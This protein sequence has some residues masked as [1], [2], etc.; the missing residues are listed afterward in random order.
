[1]PPSPVSRS[2]RAP[3]LVTGPVDGPPAGAAG[4]AELPAGG[5][6]GLTAGCWVVEGPLDPGTLRG[7]IAR[8][9]REVPL[10]VLGPG[11]VG[12]DGAQWGELIREETAAAEAEPGPARALLA[13][14]DAERSL[15]VVVTEDAL[16]PAAVMRWLLTD[17]A[18]FPAEAGAGSGRLSRSAVGPE[19]DG[20]AGAAER[21]PSGLPDGGD[22]ASGYAR[23]E[24]VPAGRVASRLPFA[25]VPVEASL[26][27]ALAV[28]RVRCGGSPGTGIVVASDAPVAVAPRVAESVSGTVALR[29]GGHALAS[30][31]PVAPGFHAALAVAP[32]A[33]T[34]PERVGACT[35]SAVRPP[36]SVAHHGLLV[37]LEDEQVRI[38]HD[39]GLY[40]EDAVATFAA[41]LLAVLEQ[42]L[43]DRPVYGIVGAG[44]AER[45]ALAEWS[46]GAEGAVPAVC[47][48]T[49]VEEHAV[50]TPDAPAVLCGETEL[51][52]RR[53]DE[54]ANAAR[55]AR[56]ARPGVGPGAR[57]PPATWT[58]GFRR[59]P[60][61]LAFYRG[62][63]LA[64]IS[65]P[66]TYAVA[67][68]WEERRFSVLEEW[69]DIGLT[70]GRH[71]ELISELKP[72]V[73]EYPMRERLCA[74]LMTALYQSQR[75]AEALAVYRN[76]RMAQIKNLGLEP[77]TGLQ[78]LHQKI[79]A[80]EPIAPP[81]SVVAHQPWP[82][83]KVPAQLPPR[84]KDFTGRRDLLQRITSDLRAGGEPRVVALA[85]C[86][87][88]G[89]TALAI[90][91]GL[92]LQ[93][94]FPDGQLYADLRGHTDPVHPQ[95]VLLGFL[96]AF[97]VPEQRIPAGLAARAALFRSITA[98]KRLLIVLDDVAESTRYE[99]LLPSG[100]SAVLCTG[101]ASLLKI[102]GLTEYRVDGLPTD[103]ALDLFASLARRGTVPAALLV[104]PLVPL[105]TNALG[106]GLVAAPV[107]VAALLTALLPGV[108]PV[109]P[110]LLP[111]TA[112]VVAT[113][114]LA[115]AALLPRE[116]ENPVRADLLYLWD[117]DRRAG[118][119]ISGVPADEW[120]DDF[121]PADAEPGSVEDL[122][123]GW[124]VPV[125][126]GPAEA[127][128]L[129]GPRVTTQVVA[130]TAD[131]GRRVRVTAASRRGADQL[132]LLVSGTAV[133]GWSLSGVPGRHADDPAGDAPWELWIRHVPARGAELELELGA[134]PATIRVVDRTQGLPGPAA[135][136]PDGTRPPALGVAS[137]GEASLAATTRT[138]E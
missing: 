91:A 131:G 121:L 125:R 134:G 109:L 28:L 57:R 124:R 2:V 97:G 122:W 24:R 3:V 4:P 86:G 82:G 83:A 11:S 74:Q 51:T 71:A 128:P 37:A 73:A 72:L 107:A 129:P 7:R 43:D 61:A 19:D 10:T 85:G 47:L 30:G 9:G 96:D 93:Q 53:L 77:S 104:F 110:R 80:G 23:T 117:A 27:V 106:L 135:D 46:R 5:R 88:A 70:L 115:G 130:R 114:M 16:P 20:R 90:H 78:E 113:A 49:L 100:E 64:D 45:A 42:L 14:L 34:E 75:R 108:L 40:E 48:H 38:D 95:E 101:R 84:I 12:T 35:A 133:R 15:L 116:P 17:D 62:Q 103:E 58:S 56:S 67:A 36:D 111:V 60:A 18:P 98:S 13:R 25:G 102:P 1:M 69:L 79:L 65:G 41:R 132:V 39:T 54:E 63:P 31:V 127:F 92:A 22:R 33:V 94:H 32:C 44:T 6:A 126:R 137:L 119:W 87:G 89:K 99:A 112:A 118:H 50:R 52:Y 81:A 120:S 59:I 66:L 26:A 136:A 29:A 8:G 105:L 55:H 138:L 123:P 68:H 21:G 76:S